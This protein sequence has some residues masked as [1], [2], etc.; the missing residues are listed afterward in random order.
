MSSFFPRHFSFTPIARLAALLLI[1]IFC[2]VQAYE[3]ECGTMRLFERLIQQRNESPYYAQIRKKDEPVEET[4]CRTE[5]FYDS[6][7][8]IETQHFQVI[9]VLTGP[10]AT[11][12]EYADSTAAIMEDAWD[13][14]CNKRK[15]NAPK[16]P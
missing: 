2:N 9:Y 3:G 12:K 10:H 11:T 13:F 6:V 7:Y 5:S 14:Y 1:S 15:M 8:T 4:S 16:G